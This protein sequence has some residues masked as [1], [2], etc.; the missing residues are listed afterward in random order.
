MRIVKQRKAFENW[1]LKVTCNGEKWTQKQAPC[2]SDLEIDIKDLY[3]RKWFKYPNTEGI[4]YGYICPVCGCFS[5]INES[6]L[7]KHMKIKAN[8]YEQRYRS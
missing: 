3:F 2:G 8:D 4:S 1:S 5:E 7:S 6:L